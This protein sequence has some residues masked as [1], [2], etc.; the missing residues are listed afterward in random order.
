MVLD[1]TRRGVR[2]AERDGVRVTARDLL[3]FRSAGREVAL[4][5]VCANVSV[6]VPFLASWL[7][8]VGAAAITRNLAEGMLAEGLQALPRHEGLRPRGR[9]PEGHGPAEAEEVFGSVTV[10]GGFPTFLTVS[11]R[12]PAAWPARRHAHMSVSVE[13][14]PLMRPTRQKP[15]FRRSTLDARR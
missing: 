7:R 13:K 9:R 1:R 15:S 14:A 2:V 6:T 10:P 8:G 3:D 12:G 11:A 5:G 4:A